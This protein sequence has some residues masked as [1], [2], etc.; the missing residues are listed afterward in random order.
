[1]PAAHGQPCG[2]L[3]RIL[4]RIFKQS[5]PEILDL[6][7]LCGQTVTYLAERGARVSVEPFEPPNPVA[8]DA[9]DPP[10]SPAI[11]FD[12]PDGQFDL[13]LAWEHLD[14]IPPESVPEFA[15][16]ISRVLRDGGWLFLFSLMAKP[17]GPEPP[18]R[19]RLLADDLIVREGSGLPA[20]RRW[21]SST[22]DIERALKGFSIQGVQLQRNQMREF[23]AV[24][25]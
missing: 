9:V 1:M 7:P 23:S 6:G 10:P 13:V 21:A 11:R 17:S 12:Q 20:R 14:F 24:K 8:E 2:S 18:S 4:A 15:Q 3:G 16:E 19:F 25:A 22:R 5:R